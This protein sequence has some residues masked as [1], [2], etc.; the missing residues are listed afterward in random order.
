VLEPVAA[1]WPDRVKTLTAD[2]NGNFRIH[3]VAPGEYRIFAWKGEEPDES[4]AVQI[5]VKPN[6]D[7]RITLRIP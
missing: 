2:D 7:H 4:R 5:E 6:G 3:D 1:D